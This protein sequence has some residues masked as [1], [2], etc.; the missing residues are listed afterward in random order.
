[1]RANLLLGAFIFEADPS[2]GT[3]FTRIAHV[4]TNGDIPSL[5]V[6]KSIGKLHHAVKCIK[7]SVEKAAK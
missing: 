3:K 2:G 5:I 4:D 6:N 1:V 7:E